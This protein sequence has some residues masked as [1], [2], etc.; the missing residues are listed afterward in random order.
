M[1]LCRLGQILLQNS[2]PNIHKQ[3]FFLRKSFIY[4]YR[5]RSLLLHFTLIYSFTDDRLCGKAEQFMCLCGKQSKKT[6]YVQ[7][8]PNVSVRSSQARTHAERVRDVYE[9]QTS[10]IPVRCSGFMRFVVTIGSAETQ[11]HSL[12]LKCTQAVKRTLARYDPITTQ[13]WCAGSCE[14]VQEICGNWNTS[15]LWTFGRLY[16]I[17]LVKLFL[18]SWS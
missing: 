4:F 5:W 9:F 15:K 7:Y 16:K 10:V 12:S 2:R 14:Q 18:K 17:C 1:G 3:R 11:H 13:G 6:V 8:K